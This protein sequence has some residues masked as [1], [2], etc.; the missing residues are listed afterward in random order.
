MIKYTAVCTDQRKRNIQDQVHS[1]Q[2]NRSENLAGFGIRVDDRKFLQVPARQLP[3]PNIEYSNG[4]VTPA[5]GQWRMDFGNKK[6]LKPV[7]CLKWCV[8]NTDPRLDSS[9]LD[10]F[11]GE[12]CTKCDSL[13]KK[14]HIELTKFRA[15][16]FSQSIFSLE[17]ISY[18]LHFDLQLYRVSQ[19]NGMQLERRPMET[20][21]Q[22]RPHEIGQCLNRMAKQ[23][24]NIVFCVVPSKGP[25]YAK[26]KKEAELVVGVLTQCIKADTISRRC[27]R[28]TLGNV[29]LKVN[30]KLTGTNHK[31]ASQT[32]PILNNF[33]NEPVMVI[34]ADVTHPAAGVT[35]GYS[36]AAVVASHDRNA[37]YYNPGWRVQIGE[38]IADFQTFV[39]EALQFFV[40][41][42]KKLP[43]KIFYFR[44]GVSDSQFKHVME[45]EWDAMLKACAASKPGYDKTVKVT[46]LIVQKRHRT[47]FFP[48]KNPISEDKNNNVP[49]GTVVDTVI[50]RGD[51]AQYY[52]CS[53]QAIQGVSR[54]TKYCILLDDG[55]HSMNDL[56]A[57]TYNVSESNQLPFLT[58]LEF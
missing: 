48:A 55:N 2:Y 37:F 35:N 58:Y 12:V 19:T 29:L 51:E 3:P 5:K 47:R 34:G 11:V 13:K 27:D 54:P 24:V 6:F 7:N 14:K 9:D 45:S 28:M 33:E 42:N 1:I 23:N 44:D 40:K 49:A 17:P 57:L 31:L 53:H 41:E 4:M 10:T 26:I 20:I 56:Q 8:L 46:I 18:M 15:D 36:V 43:S 39:Q 16:I 52:L 32:S 50:S 30:A 21:R 22:C 25:N 38:I